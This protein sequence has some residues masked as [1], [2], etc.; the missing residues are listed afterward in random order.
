MT[1]FQSK[2]VCTCCN[3][4]SL[5]LLHDFGQVPLAGSFVKDVNQNELYPLSISVC[6]NCY[7]VQVNEYID[8]DILFA[9]YRY[10]SGYS[11]KNHFKKYLETLK[12]RY[13]N[14]S[15][16]NVLEIGSNDGTFLS[17]LKQSCQSVVGVEPSTNVS[18]VSVRRGDNVIVDYFNLQTLIK[19]NISNGTF[20]IITASNC[21][22][23]IEDIDSIIE[24][25][26]YLLKP[27]S[28]VFVVEVHYSPKM[29][30]ELQYDFIYHEHMYYYCLNSLDELF[31][32]NG[33]HIFDFEFIPVHG[34]SIRVFIMQGGYYKKILKVETQKEF[35]K[36]FYKEFITSGKFSES[37]KNHIYNSRR[38]VENIK[39]SGMNIVGF[40]ASGRVNAFLNYSHITSDYID[41]IFDDSP[42]RYDRI[43]PNVNIPVKKFNS[44]NQIPFDV[45]FIGAWN[46]SQAIISKSEKLHHSNTLM[47]FPEI[48]YKRK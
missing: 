36:L 38:I 25:V 2:N 37:V 11:M 14:F 41:F 33:M 35:E 18:Q 32:R 6:Q 22:A 27:K 31:R 44:L 23:H 7:N 10:M 4:S 1:K 3:S 43:I 8:A 47:F 39:D 9:D 45:L 40:G 48:E 29:L 20:D 24:G 13:K 21:F 5:K 15:N 19:N 30:K 16:F 26:K 12:K 42:E 28:G 17:M 46:F 34:G